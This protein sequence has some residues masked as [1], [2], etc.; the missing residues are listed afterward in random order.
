MFVGRAFAVGLSRCSPGGIL[1][2]DNLLEHKINR[3]EIQENIH[4][5]NAEVHVN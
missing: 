1:I 4:T 2:P 3:R 5:E